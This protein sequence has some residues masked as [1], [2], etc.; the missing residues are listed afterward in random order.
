MPLHWAVFFALSTC[1][2]LIQGFRITDNDLQD[3]SDSDEEGMDMSYNDYAKMSRQFGNGLQASE[4]TGSEL[5]DDVSD[6]DER[7]ERS[8][9]SSSQ[10]FGI[11]T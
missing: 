5:D 10:P 9:S 1:L 11:Y 8:K 2:S 3:L 4:I 7:H 6:L